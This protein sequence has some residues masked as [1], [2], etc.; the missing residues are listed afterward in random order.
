MP[1]QRLRRRLQ[2]RVGLDWAGVIAQADRDHARRHAPRP[3]ARDPA[4]ASPMWTNHFEPW[5]APVT[6]GQQKHNQELLL[7][8]QRT[9]ART[10]E[11]MAEA[12]Q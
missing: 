5:R 6:T 9:T 1:R 2:V 8:A 10:T 12:S 7:L 11:T 4:P 3:P